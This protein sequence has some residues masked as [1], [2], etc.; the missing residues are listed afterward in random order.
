MAAQ[1]SKRQI[2]PPKAIRMA[3]HFNHQKK[4]IEFGKQRP[5]LNRFHFKSPVAMDLT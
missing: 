1:Q 2:C 5:I 4:F 3:L